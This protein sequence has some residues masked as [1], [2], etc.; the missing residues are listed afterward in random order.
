M[1]S[2]VAIAASLYG[3]TGGRVDGVVSRR[4]VI[5][6]PQVECERVLELEGESVFNMMFRHTTSRVPSQV[7]SVE[8]AEVYDWLTVYHRCC[9]WL[10]VCAL[11]CPWEACEPGN[12]ELLMS[13]L[14]DEYLLPVYREQYVF[15]Q[16]RCV[17]SLL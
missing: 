5:V 2:R 3:H 10:A 15:L 9:D 7:G 12:W 13:R 11:A 8:N 4:R 14:S 6:P 16:V 1:V 17:L